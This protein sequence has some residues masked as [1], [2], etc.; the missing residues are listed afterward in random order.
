M[1]I[2][3]IKHSI[4]NSEYNNGVLSKEGKEVTVSVAGNISVPLDANNGVIYVDYQFV[5]GENES[6]P[7]LVV[8]TRTEFSFSDK[9]E[10]NYEF[11]KNNCVPEA[12]KRLE[13]DVNRILKSYGEEEVKFPELEDK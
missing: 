11:V 3:L 8:N 2:K 4:L 6:K 13:N 5:L 9:Q 7:I 12:E 10:T 1:A